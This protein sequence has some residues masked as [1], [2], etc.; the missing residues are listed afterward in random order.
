[1]DVTMPTHPPSESG[2]AEFLALYQEPGPLYLGVGL[3]LAAAS[4]ALFYVFDVVNGLLGALGGL[5]TVRVVLMVILFA[6][7]LAAIAWK[8]FVARHYVQIASVTSFV[9]LQVVVW[10]AFGVRRSQ[11]PAELFW[12]LATT[13]TASLLVLYGFVQLRVGLILVIALSGTLSAVSLAASVPNVQPAYLERLIINL[14]T[15]NVIAF[16]FRRSIEKRERRLF[17]LVKENLAS[18]IYTKELEVANHEAALAN[19]AKTQFLANMSHEVRTP[20]HGLLQIF[21]LVSP[22]VSPQHRALMEKGFNSGKA[23]L[24]ILNGILDYTKLSNG[25][26]EVVPSVV[27]LSDTCRTVL[28]LHTAALAVKGLELKLRLDLVPLDDRVRVDEVKLFEIINNLV[29][30]A[31]KFTYQGYV[32]I[33]VRVLRRP[34]T[35]LPDAQLELTISD[36][37]VGL[38]VADKTKAFAPFY[39]VDSGASRKAGGTGLGLAIV[40]ELVRLLG[41]TIQVESALSVG[42]TFTVRI[43]VEMTEDAVVALAPR[44]PVV[45]QPSSGAEVISFPVA[46]PA[47]RPLLSGRILLVEDNDLNAALTAYLLGVIGLEVTAAMNGLEGFQEFC[48]S[49]F[50]AVL[51]DCQM[52]TMDGYEATRQIRAYEGRAGLAPSPIIAFT[53]NTLEGDREACVEAGMSD[54]IG[55]PA[56]E[57][58]LRAILQ[59]WIGERLARAE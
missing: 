39:Q 33:Q 23:L 36:T 3:F 41:G 27:S 31:I 12:A 30:N 28:D 40:D 15:V 51:M 46:E 6:F 25:A 18:N 11:P 58:D 21:E 4:L 17:E 52:P 53:A 20:M 26:E 38:S 56:D 42:T 35:P 7:G 54:Y 55:K 10:L 16:W 8:E 1:M 47:R 57:E 59:K 45:P 22:A 29:S 19:R 32:G 50:D 14:I 2:D 13:L 24:R 34:H 37:G 48:K 44:K 5:Q 43:P 49:K 9:L